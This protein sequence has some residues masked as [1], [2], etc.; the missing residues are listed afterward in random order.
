MYAL[1]FS[2][3][4]THGYILARVRRGPFLRVRQ[5][6]PN[7]SKKKMLFIFIRLHITSY[8]RILEYNIRARNI[9]N[10]V[11]QNQLEW[12]YSYVLHSPPVPPFFQTSPPLS[13]AFGPPVLFLAFTGFW[14]DSV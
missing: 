11:N 5:K 1:V 12:M 2:S 14:S 8:S 6:T 3:R 4:S 10:I 7:V 13:I 9:N